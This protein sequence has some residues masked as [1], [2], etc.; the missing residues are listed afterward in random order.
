V[1]EKVAAST[2]R[3]D[4]QTNLENKECGRRVKD[5]VLKGTNKIRRIV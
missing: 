2:S 3:A 4:E 5:D 1:P